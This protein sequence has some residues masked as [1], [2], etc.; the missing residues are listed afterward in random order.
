MVM[1][2]MVVPGESVD[3]LWIDGWGLGTIKDREPSLPPC[4]AAGTAAW[5][6]ACVGYRK[7]AEAAEKSV[8]KKNTINEGLKA[9][10]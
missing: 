2:W 10:G 4:L 8:G 1:T 5:R 6:T 7:A 3:R 9:A